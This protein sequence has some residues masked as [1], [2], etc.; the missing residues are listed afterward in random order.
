M[1][2]RSENQHQSVNVLK[3]VAWIRLFEDAADGSTS[4]R[5]VTV[6]EALLQAHIFKGIDTSLNG[7]QFGA[8]SRFLFSV[9]AIVIR[10]QDPRRPFSKFRA[11]KFS[12]AA[13][14]AAINQLSEY[15]DLFH[16]E[17]PFLQIAADL[18]IPVTSSVK[19]LLPYMPPDR[20]EE[21]WSSSE[22]PRSLDLPEAVLAL[23]INSYYS[24]GGNNRLDGRA[25]VNGSPGIRYPGKDFTA[26]EVLWHGGSLFDFICF[27]VPKSW[28]EGTGLPAWADPLGATALKD[29]KI[30]EHPLWRATWGS[31]TA[32]CQWRDF[33][34]VAAAVG[35]SPYR[36]PLMGTEKHEAKKWW[37]LRNTYDPFY[38]Y[39]PVKDTSGGKGASP[40]EVKAQ[41]LDFG[42]GATQ[43]EAEW[44][45]KNLSAA[46]RNHSQGRIMVDE[47][48]P[49][50]F[51]RHLVQGS[52][53]S[54]V[55]RRSEILVSARSRW[56]I[57]ES[58]ADAVSEASTKVKL[59]MIELGKPFSK[60]G[61]LAAI[62]NRRGDVEA[63]FWA[64]VRVPF[65]HYIVN[66]SNDVS[67]DPNVWAEVREAALKAFDTVAQSVPHSKIAPALSI[68][69]NRVGHNI[70]RLLNLAENS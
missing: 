25:C 6:R 69:R 28:V 27:N 33:Q 10:N 3:D 52:A 16:P 11:M 44:H 24:F 20:A 38:L 67:I 36:P 40:M 5:C 66:G 49:L 21:F 35:G 45:A 41:R 32:R 12:E 17:K 47:E 59:V 65:A 8:I 56:Q 51:L 23:A 60:K 18:E 26:T 30:A 61:R 31:N 53:S 22:Q 57:S 46:L 9:A 2:Q 58:R 70:A 15:A 48:A 62:A 14:D 4:T 64:E 29:Q 34:M 55:V 39:L 63:E 13:I 19:K 37:D 7:V 50:V 43:L 54:P 42:Y 68:A 1:S